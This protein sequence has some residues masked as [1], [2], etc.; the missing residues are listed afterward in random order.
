MVVILVVV[1]SLEEAMVSGCE[2]SPSILKYIGIEGAY[3]AELWGVLEGHMYA[4]RL[5]FRFIE[6]HVDSLVVVMSKLSLQRGHGSLR[7]R[8][9]VDKIHRLLALDSEV[10]VPPLLP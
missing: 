7:G 4:R 9:L 1:A 3:L 8:S 2:V 5:Q 10:V 6:V